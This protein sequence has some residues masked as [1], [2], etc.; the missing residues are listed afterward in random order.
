MRSLFE[1]VANVESSWGRLLAVHGADVPAT[2]FSLVLA[3]PLP[4]D[5]LDMSAEV[6]VRDDTLSLGALSIWIDPRSVEHHGLVPAASPLARVS[7][8]L[9]LLAPHARESV[10]G[11]WWEEPRQEG[12]GLAAHTRFRA[13]ARLAEIVSLV[14]AEPTLAEP[15]FHAATSLVGFG[16]GATPS[17]DDALVGFFGA[18]ARFDPPSSIPPVVSGWLTAE[19]ARRTTRLAAEF[20]HHL[21]RGRLSDPLEHLL[22]AIAVHDPDRVSAATGVL[23]GQGATSG[24]DT[25]AGVHA[26]LL[27]LAPSHRARRRE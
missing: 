3:E 12:R 8:A 27:A 18:W 25:I 4:R 22:A 11:A 6:V 21:A 2:P 14:A 23:A 9:E 20:Y 5:R 19:A 26:L 1:R 10:F 15:V 24:R 7:P 17:G 16:P 13:A